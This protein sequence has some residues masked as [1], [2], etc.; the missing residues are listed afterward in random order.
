MLSVRTS[1]GCERQLDLPSGATVED[2]LAAAVCE[3]LISPAA[4]PGAVLVLMG[5][6]PRRL[7]SAATLQA[8]AVPSGGLSCLFCLHTTPPFRLF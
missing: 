8:A 3:Q 6:L 7:P 4:I 2:V 1:A 5:S